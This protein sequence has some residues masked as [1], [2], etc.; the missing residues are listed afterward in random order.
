[1]KSL[2]AGRAGLMIL[3]VCGPG[4]EENFSQQRCPDCF[5]PGRHICCVAGEMG[6]PQGRKSS[7]FSQLIDTEEQVYLF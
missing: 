3:W 5:L 2:L 7:L 1:M 4:L 6:E